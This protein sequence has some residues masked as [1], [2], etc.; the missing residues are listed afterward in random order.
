[1]HVVHS[2]EDFSP[3]ALK[4]AVIFLLPVL[5]S[6]QTIGYAADAS[7]SL[8]FQPV[9]RRFLLAELFLCWK[10]PSPPSRRSAWPS[11]TAIT[12]Q[13][14]GFLFC[15]ADMYFKN[16]YRLQHTAD[17]EQIGHVQSHW[18]CVKEE[19]NSQWV[20]V[21]CEDNDIIDFWYA[22]KTRTNRKQ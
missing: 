17:S 8:F 1:M 12:R 10:Q 9:L 20:N 19:Q 22:Y 21:C 5:H 16:C 7:L 6:F 4:S 18:K 14:V 3:S 13:T 15:C 11:A 2:K